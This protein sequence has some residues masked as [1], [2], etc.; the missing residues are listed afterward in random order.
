MAEEMMDTVRASELSLEQQQE[1]QAIKEEIKNK[2]TSI[3]SSYRW[4]KK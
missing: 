4:R 3:F 2:E 1:I